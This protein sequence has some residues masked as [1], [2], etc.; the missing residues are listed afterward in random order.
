[1]RFYDPAENNGHSDAAASRTSL[2]FV[3]TLT[4]DLVRSPSQPNMIEP[5][6]PVVFKV[7]TSGTP[8]CP[9]ERDVGGSRSLGHD[10]I[11]YL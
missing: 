8:A 2:Y 4:L 1:M 6:R 7:K 11:T 9:L 5:P 10:E 3:C